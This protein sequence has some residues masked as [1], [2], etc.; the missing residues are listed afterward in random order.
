LISAQKYQLVRQSARSDLLQNSA[1]FKL[2][3][4]SRTVRPNEMNKQRCGG[5]QLIKRGE[6][7]FLL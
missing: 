1:N 2:A 7:D 6:P 5:D 3:P 4:G